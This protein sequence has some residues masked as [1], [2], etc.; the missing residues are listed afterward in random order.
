MTKQEKLL[1]ALEPEET[2]EWQEEPAVVFALINNGNL[3]GIVVA[4]LFGILFVSVGVANSESG[5][6]SWFFLG[7]AILLVANALSDIIAVASSTYAIT[8]RRL[9]IFRISYF[10]RVVES[11][12]PQDIEFVKIRRWRSGRG[13]IVFSAVREKKGK[14]TS[15]VEIGFF[16]LRNVDVV[17]RHL[18]AVHK[19]KLMFN[20]VETIPQK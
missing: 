6:I 4:V 15:T 7:F 20:L 19:N 10:S 11:F 5:A 18:L 2:I 13:S 9:I 3:L 14:S 17:E 8:N 16:G 12:Y 1:K